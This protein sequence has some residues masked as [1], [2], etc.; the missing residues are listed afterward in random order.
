MLTLPIQKAEFHFTS[1]CC[2]SMLK[3]VLFKKVIRAFTITEKK[4][5]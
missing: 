4:K 2:L 1:D 5:K 3:A